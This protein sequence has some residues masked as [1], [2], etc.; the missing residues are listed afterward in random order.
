MNECTQ[1]YLILNEIRST[2]MMYISWFV[3]V[4][5]LMLYPN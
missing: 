4:E 2:I 3:G 5:M 1:Y